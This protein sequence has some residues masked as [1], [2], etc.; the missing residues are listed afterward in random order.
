MKES[1]VKIM[2]RTTINNVKFNMNQNL[3]LENNFT[4][5]S[6]DC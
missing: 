5:V 1:E 6:M 3:N 4:S 2:I